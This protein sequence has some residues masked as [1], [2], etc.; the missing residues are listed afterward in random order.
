MRTALIDR[1][2]KFITAL[3][4]ID[5]YAVFTQDND[6]TKQGCQWYGIEGKMYYVKESKIILIVTDNIKNFFGGGIVKM[7]ILFP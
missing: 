4:H 6:K 3:P 2:L 5:K 1:T 7:K